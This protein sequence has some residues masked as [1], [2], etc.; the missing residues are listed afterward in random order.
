M[1][2]QKYFLSFVIL[3]TAQAESFL[4]RQA[5]IEEGDQPRIVGG[6]P[7]VEKYESFGFGN[8]CGGTLIHDD[9]FLT[10]AHCEAAFAVNTNLTIGGL[11]RNRTDGSSHEIEKLFLHEDYDISGHLKNDI[12]IVKLKASA[13]GVPIQDLNL[14]G[15]DPAPT[16]SVKYIGFG[17]LEFNTQNTPDVLHEVDVAVSTHTQCDIYT[18]GINDATQICTLTPGKDACQGDSG[19]SSFTL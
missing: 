17:V 1:L 14:E 12:M 9:L 19:T 13:T 4:R 18:G 16:T 10:A 11:F 3:A 8:G 15:S 6:Q 2:A 5:Q 7:S